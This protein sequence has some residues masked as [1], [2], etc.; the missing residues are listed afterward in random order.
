MIEIITCNGLMEA[1]KIVDDEI[2]WD[3]YNKKVYDERKIYG[4]VGYL[5][6]KS[7]VAKKTK[8]KTEKLRHNLIKRELIGR[9]KKGK[10]PFFA[11][12]LQPVFDN[13]IK[14]KKKL[15][16]ITLRE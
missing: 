7:K 15:V 5:T 12:H 14:R 8:Q 10:Q 1:V 11:T 16:R 3:V 13:N 2:S 9:R 6:S 4:F